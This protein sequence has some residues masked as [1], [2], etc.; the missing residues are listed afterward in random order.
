MADPDATR[1]GRSS[2]SKKSSG[3][4][5][6]RASGGVG[7]FVGKSGANQAVLIGAQ[8][9]QQYL[10]A[11]QMA[12]GGGM[13]QQGGGG[14]AYVGGGGGGGYGGPSAYDQWRIAEEKRRREELEKQKKILELGLAGQKQAAVPRIQQYGREARQ[15]V[16][17]AYGQNAQQTREYTNQLRSLGSQMTGGAMQELAGLQRDIGAQGGGGADMRALQ[18]AAQQNVTGQQFL[19]NNADAYNRRLAQVQ[20]GARADALSTANTVQDAGLADLESA[21]MQALMQ[22]RLLGLT[23]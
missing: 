2:G 3:G 17:N 20:S 5:G 4:G 22:I 9:D 23:G 18:A 8:R 10:Q 15:R 12:L 13:P 1:F 21:Y 11:L 16:M 7:S 19:T 14:R 6:R